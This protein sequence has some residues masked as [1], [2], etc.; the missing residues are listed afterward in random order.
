MLPLTPG[1]WCVLFYFQI[2]TC[3]GCSSCHSLGCQ[4][5]WHQSIAT[6]RH[7]IIPDPRHQNI[8]NLRHQS[9]ANLRHQSIANCRHQSIDFEHQSISN[10]RYQSIANPRPSLPFCMSWTSA[11][12][13][14]MSMPHV[15]Q[16]FSRY[17][18]IG[19]YLVPQL[20]QIQHAADS[21]EFISASVRQH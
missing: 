6:S 3:A 8:A 18:S 19:P 17:L 16:M 13:D 4:D 5:C 20:M 1:M 7:Q 10:P 12:Q 21:H 9:I 14:S 2:S 15:L 11:I